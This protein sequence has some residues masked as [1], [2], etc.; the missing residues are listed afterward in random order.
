MTLTLRPAVIGNETAKND[1]N[2]MEDGRSIG[3]IR[4][5]EERSWNGG[6]NWLWGV[7]VPLP[8]PPWCG[9]N[10]ASLEAAK[11]AFKESWE[12]FRASMTDH[13]VDHWH[14]H[15]DAASS[16]RPWHV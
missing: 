9:G 10:A 3:R 11:V 7:N 16:G 12:R 8:I 6:D 13:D 15:E 1:Y 14:H 2:V 5:A 4:L